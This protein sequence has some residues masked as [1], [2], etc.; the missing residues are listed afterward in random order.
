[1]EMTSPDPTPGLT[2]W[3]IVLTGALFG[4]AAGILSWLGGVLVPLAILTGGGAFCG[5]VLLI[6]ALLNYGRG[7]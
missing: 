7:R 6:I 2:I 4:S 5:T 3:L 1:M